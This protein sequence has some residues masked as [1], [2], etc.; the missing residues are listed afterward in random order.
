[1]VN[2][3]RDDIAYTILDIEQEPTPALIEEIS[4]V[5]HVFHV[6]SV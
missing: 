2:K 4:N 6:R 3:S 1:M 5:E